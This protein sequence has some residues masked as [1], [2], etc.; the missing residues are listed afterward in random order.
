MAKRKIYSLFVFIYGEILFSGASSKKRLAHRYCCFFMFFFSLS[1]PYRSV[2]SCFIH[3][4]T[5][6]MMLWSFQS[7]GFIYQFYLAIEC[8]SNKKRYIIYLFVTLLN[9]FYR[10]SD[11]RFG[12]LSLF[13]MLNL[14]VSVNIFNILIIQMK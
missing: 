13:Q 4:F 10:W 9:R 12:M 8:C 1:M 6:I 2:F 7:F 11:D 3:A 5:H 14:L